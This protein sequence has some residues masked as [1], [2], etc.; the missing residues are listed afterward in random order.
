[1]RRRP[2]QELVAE[3]LKRVEGALQ[4]GQTPKEERN[5][6]VGLN[7]HS[8]PRAQLALHLLAGGLQ[9]DRVGLR[10][11]YEGGYNVGA[12]VPLWSKFRERYGESDKVTNFFFGS[13]SRP[14]DRISNIRDE[15]ARNYRDMP[16]YVA[17]P[18]PESGSSAVSDAGDSSE[19]VRQVEEQ[20]ESARRELGDQYKPIYEPVID[21]VDADGS[22]SF[23]LAVDRGV[24]YLVVGVCDNDCDDVDLL[25]YDDADEEVVSGFE[26]DDYPVLAFSART[27]GSWSVEVRMPGCSADTCIFGFQV[28]ER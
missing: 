3:H 25:V 9:A 24:D 19:W 21:E 17:M 6:R 13:H 22:M 7:R 5:E 8:L 4:P 28:F 10:Y 23:D 16:E 18:V 1:M 14:S 27:A 2:A 26:P 12:G 15:I 11:A 20:L